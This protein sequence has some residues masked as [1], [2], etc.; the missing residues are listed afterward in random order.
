[1]L[2]ERIYL[3]AVLVH[4]LGGQDVVAIDAIE[5]L[6]PETASNTAYNMFLR[7]EGQSIVFGRQA[8]FSET[9][10]SFQVEVLAVIDIEEEANKVWRRSIEVSREFFKRTEDGE[11]D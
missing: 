8:F 4:L 11:R 10:A 3:V 6:S 2:E 9:V 5:A 7:A 1:M